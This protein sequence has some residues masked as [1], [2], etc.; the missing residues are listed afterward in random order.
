MKNQIIEKIANT[1]F[2]IHPILKRRW[3][4]RTFSDMPISDVDI[5]TL[6]EAGRWAP[7]SNNI[8][9]WKII[10]GVKGS[11]TYERIFKHLAEFN[12]SWVVNAPLL[13]LTA[14]DTKM[15]DGKD[16]F[17]ALHD[18]GL[19]LAQMTFQAEHNGI[20]AHQMA[21]VDFEKAKTE[22]RLPND[23]HVASAVAFGYYGGDVENLPEKLK[24]LEQQ[25]ERERKSII[26]FS[27]NGDFVDREKL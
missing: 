21:G 6:L 17:H 16:N 1:E 12:Q 25:T 27:F 10:W 18:L 20:A 23:F 2:D 7:S 8:Q 14:Y 11:E 13:I 15:P 24:K 5:K 22:F 9:P 26:E 4:P 19:F 3:S